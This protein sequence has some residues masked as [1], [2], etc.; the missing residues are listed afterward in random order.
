MVYPV[1]EGGRGGGRLRGLLLL[2]STALTAPAA[3]G[4]A[5]ERE[6]AEDDGAG[7]KKLGRLASSFGEAKSDDFCTPANVGETLVLVPILL[8]EPSLVGE[9]CLVPDGGNIEVACAFSPDLS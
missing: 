7:G 6:E 3:D 9:A 1:C 5:V 2:L 4:A 8:F